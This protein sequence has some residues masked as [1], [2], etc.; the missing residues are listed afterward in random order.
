M[1]NL[2]QLQEH[3]SCLRGG[4]GQPSLQVTCTAGKVPNCCQGWCNADWDV[5]APTAKGR[6]VVFLAGD[7][8][9]AA[10]SADREQEQNV[11][12][13]LQDVFFSEVA[14]FGSSWANAEGLIC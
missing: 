9:C 10:S 14:V 4:G 2:V 5:Q 7:T 6:C 3:G 11:D 8:V 1:S 13:N 12:L